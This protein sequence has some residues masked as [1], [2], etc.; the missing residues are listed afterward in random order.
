M[1]FSP[2]P[3]VQAPGNWANY[4]RYAYVL[5]NPMRYTDPSGYRYYPQFYENEPKAGGGGSQGSYMFFP[6]ELGDNTG[7]VAGYGNGADA[8]NPYSLNTWW[9]AYIQSTFNGFTG[10][11]DNFLNQYNKQVGKSG[12]NGTITLRYNARYIVSGT[13][14]GNNTGGYTLPEVT[15]IWGKI[16]LNVGDG[17]SFV[18]KHFNGGLGTVGVSVQGYNKIPNDIKR[19]YAY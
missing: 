16:T 15:T 11:L 17:M 13:T 1:F 14:T 6:G 18:D 9:N 8:V 3:F 10:G 4:N 5:N 12:F 2:D 19:A 7:Y